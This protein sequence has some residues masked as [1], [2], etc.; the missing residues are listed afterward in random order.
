LWRFVVDRI[1]G[2]LAVLEIEGPNGFTTRL[3]TTR[4]RGWTEGAVYRWTGRSWVRDRAEE[5]R[6]LEAAREWYRAQPD[7]GGPL[8][9]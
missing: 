1:E 3:T 6:R 8:A 5:R 2:T 9:L 4:Q 7:T